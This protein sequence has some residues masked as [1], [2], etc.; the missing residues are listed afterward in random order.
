M[1][2]MG[3]SSTF[4]F[5]SLSEGQLQRLMA[6]AKEVQIQK[7]QWLF[8]E[9]ETADRVYILKSGAVEMLTKVDDTFELP[10]R[11]IRSQWGCFGISSL[12]P[13]YEYSL[14][15]RCVED[16]VLMEFRREDLQHLTREDSTIGCTMMTNLA[17]HLLAR[18]KE[19]RQEVKIHF[20]TL[21]RSMHS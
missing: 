5:K 11:I 9:G 3:L 1:E 8:Q 21:F 13:P 20:K 12:V 4:L 16:A 14:S 6:T 19:T 15:S 18:L 10:I 7:G 2:S 17:Q